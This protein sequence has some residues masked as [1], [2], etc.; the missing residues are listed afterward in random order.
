MCSILESFLDADGEI[1]I[2][3][4]LSPCIYQDSLTLDI[5]K[6]ANICTNVM[7]SALKVLSCFTYNSALLLELVSFSLN[8]YILREREC[9]TGKLPLMLAYKNAPAYNDHSFWENFCIPEKE[10]VTRTI[11]RRRRRRRNKIMH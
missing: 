4:L 11:L 7:F 3:I 8:K 9:V 6:A 2:T 5:C 1:R 10:R